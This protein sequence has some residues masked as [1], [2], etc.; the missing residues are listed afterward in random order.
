MLSQVIQSII[1]AQKQNAAMPPYG[2]GSLDPGATISTAPDPYSAMNTFGSPS[3]STTPDTTAS[4]ASPTTP[5]VPGFSGVNPSDLYSA[6]NTARDKFQQDLL[7]G[8]PQAPQMVGPHL[9]LL[10]LLGLGL[11]GTIAN[12]ERPRLMQGTQGVDAAVGSL[13][14]QANLTNQ[15]AQLQFQNQNAQRQATLGADQNAAQNAQSDLGGYQAAALKQAELQ[16]QAD[17]WGQRNA[18][19]AGNAQTRANASMFNASQ[20]AS[21]KHYVIDKASQDKQLASLV[22][23]IAKAPPQMRSGLYNQARSSYPQIFGQLTDDQIAQASNLTPK[24]Q[25][26]T[27]HAAEQTSKANELDQQAKLIQTQFGLAPAEIAQIQA[28]T[29]DIPS[30]DA[31]KIAQSYANVDNLENLSKDRTFK[32]GLATNAQAQQLYGQQIAGVR[33]NLNNLSAQINQLSRERGAMLD[34]MIK[35]GSTPK[36]IAAAVAPY[37]QQITKMR[38]MYG[39][40][41]QRASGIQRNLGTVNPDG[42]LTVP[43]GPQATVTPGQGGYAP[44]SF[45]G[46]PG[47]LTTGVPPGTGTFNGQPTPGTPPLQS[48][49]KW[50]KGVLPQK[51]AWYMQNKDKISPSDRQTYRAAI[52]ANGGNVP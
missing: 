51:I 22:T 47:G 46:T 3:G 49:P 50:P 26:D 18:T 32:E 8:L 42:T 15:N 1:A 17:I 43:Q 24:E 40:L 16:N 52:L 38:V 30:L 28:I 10:A 41:S 31:A 23:E 9:P 4:P 35:G 5:G 19:S 12:R 44:V 33:V 45:G 29:K 13:N 48:A 6:R 25:A 37:D 21:A 27:A 11:A 2:G 7:N 34:T 20:A 39:E 36:D 14:N